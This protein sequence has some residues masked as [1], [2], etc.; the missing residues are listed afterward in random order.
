[1]KNLIVRVYLGSKY[2][3]KGDSTNI[4]QISDIGIMSCTSSTGNSSEYNLPN[5]TANYCRRSGAG[6]IQSM[7]QM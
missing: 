3:S 4:Q 1:M 5:T 7:P 2:L 6:K